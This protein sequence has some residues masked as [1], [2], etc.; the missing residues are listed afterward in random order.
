MHINT[1]IQIVFYIDESVAGA[2][3]GIKL[4]IH[5]NNKNNKI[6]KID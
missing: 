3:H 5:I 1:S 2:A 4:S 6:V